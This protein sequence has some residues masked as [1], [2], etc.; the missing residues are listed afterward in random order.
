MEDILKLI[1]IV[2]KKGS[3]SIQLLNQNFR[4]SEISKDNQLFDII[5]NNELKNDEEAAELLFKTKP[6]NRNYRNAKS[7][8]RQK[9]Y[10]HL[11][12]LD[13]EKKEYTTYQ[14]YE[15]DCLHELHQARILINEGA[16]ELATKILLQLLKTAKIC[17]FV[18]IVVQALLLLKEQ[19]AKHGKLSLYNEVDLALGYYLNFQ[20]AVRFSE[21]LYFNELVLINKSVS[22]Q[23]RAL[24]HISDSIA[25]INKK[26]I[27]F[28]S[29]RIEIYAI[30]LDLLY[31][32]IVEDYDGY[33]ALSDDI[34]RDYLQRKDGEIRVDIDPD[35]FYLQKLI[36]YF[37]SGKVLEGLEFGFSKIDNFRNGGNIWFEFMEYMFLMAIQGDKYSD[38]SKLFR[39]VK[40]HPQ[41][42][43][44]ENLEVERWTIYRAYLLLFDNSKLIRWGFNLDKFLVDLPLHSREYQGYSIAT[45]V[46]QFIHH[47]ERCQIDELRLVMERLQEFNSAH[48]DKRSNYR[49][50]IFI[51]LLNLIDENQ[52][53]HEVIEEKSRLYYQKLVENRIPQ[54][55]FL[56]LE[57]YP[58]EK[59][60]KR[61]LDV[62]K[63]EKEY[64]HFRFYHYS[65]AES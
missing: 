54:E 63:N 46:V 17:D 51:R 27:T 2:K 65:E 11:Y 32:W 29:S 42:A 24:D 35:N 39:E 1:G 8:L 57:V 26:A 49:N 44:L 16:E 48:L 47:L 25:K 38:A 62:L 52:F 4:K 50:S 37:N 7:K 9:L 21:N 28:N 53:H 45:L 59:L 43:E 6:N 19:Y 18:D 58:Y 23:T 20:D 36:V 41:F 12:F 55:R 64:V 14:K 3:R 56:D 15:Y 30:K 5:I 22:A 60:W 34:E 40:T 13:Y 61:I 33:L 31:K 10:N